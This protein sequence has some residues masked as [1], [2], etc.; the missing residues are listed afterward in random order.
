MRRSPSAA[1][2]TRSSTV[3]TPGNTRRPEAAI[4][5]RAPSSPGRWDSRRASIGDVT[6]G[7]CVVQTFR[8]AR[9][10]RPEGLHYDDS[11]DALQGFHREQETHNTLT[12]LLTFFVASTE[13][14][15][16]G[17]DRAKSIAFLERAVAARP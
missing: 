14:T 5:P 15:Q 10:G 3:R 11:S 2:T 13:G 17:D 7:A 8:S 4:W 1:R 6:S 16:P 12:L 9:H